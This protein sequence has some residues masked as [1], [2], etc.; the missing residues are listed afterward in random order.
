MAETPLPAPSMR[1]LIRELWFTRRDLV[2]DGYDQALDALGRAV[3]MTVHEFATGEPC[4]TWRIPEKWTLERARLETLDGRTVLDAAEHPLHAMS[5]SESFTGEVSREELFTHLHTQPRLSQ[6]IPFGFSYYRRTWGLCCSEEA[7]LAL[8]EDRYR[9]D[10]R[11]RF[12]PGALKVGEVVAPGESDESMVLCA[13]LCHPCMVND[14]LAGVVAGIDVM[15]RLLARDRRRYTWRLLLLPETIGSAAWLSR[16]EDLIPSIRGGLFLEMLATPHPHSLQR[17]N[18]PDSEMDLLCELAL[19][20]ADPEGWSAP[21]MQVILNDERMFNS[22]G[23]DVPMCSLSRVLPKGHEHY[24]YLEYHTSLDD[25]EHMVPANLEASRDLVLALADMAER[26]EVPV[27]RYKGELFVSGY[28][29]LD[30]GR[31]YHLIHSVPYRMD[32]R[33]TVAEIARDT[34]NSF[35]EVRRFLDLLAGEGLVEL[36][37]K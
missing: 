24:P 11:T 3:P 1:D 34:G 35:A 6:A 2:S 15:R 8:T 33:R 27:P 28:P 5:Y 22:P 7:K 19:A 14:D 10:I 12:E 9:V 29:S 31:M 16:H 37:R 36:R 26:N 20:E 32:G 17:S 21:F 13:H 18:Q 23:V 4:F 25:P 30:Y